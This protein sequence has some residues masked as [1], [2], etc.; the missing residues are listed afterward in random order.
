[1]K[2]HADDVFC[3]TSRRTFLATVTGGLLAAPLV[4]S[5]QQAG[6]VY[7]VGFVW[8]SP[9]VWPHA[10]EAFRQGL[11]DLGWVEGQNIIVEYRWAEGR[12]ERLPSLM[13]ELIRLKVDLIIAPTSIYTGAAKRATSTIPIVFVSHADPIGSGHVASL[14]RPGTNATGLTII[15]SETM[16]KSVELLRATIP[17]LTRVAVIWDPATPSHAP[18]LK[19]VAAVSRTF[20]LRLQ[21]LAVRSATEFDSAFSA[22][23]RERADAVLVLSTPLF[24]GEAN[25]L[26]VLALTH[27]LPTMFGPREHVEAGGLLSYGPDRADLYRRA[28]AY[29]DKILKGANPADLPVQQATKF[30][31]VIN[32]KTA[33]ALGLTIPQS[34]LL[35]ADEVIQ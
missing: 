23:V 11:R 10:L 8:D 4:A 33:K 34:V 9:T 27:K 12:F 31:L 28:A 5:A 19:A 16:A 17:G 22:I 21:A 2:L 29:V 30:E 24:M 18:G 15:M 3:M 35:R 14:A 26:A 6:K 13:E 7:R 32:L 20:G 25:R 1:M